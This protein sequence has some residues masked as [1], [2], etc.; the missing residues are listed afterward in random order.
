MRVVATFIDVVIHPDSNSLL[1]LD[2]CP[3]FTVMMCYV[4][5]EIMFF[6]AS[7]PFFFLFLFVS[8]FWVCLCIC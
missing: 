4:N 6:V 7:F 3:Q 1:L 5:E 2:T 8:F